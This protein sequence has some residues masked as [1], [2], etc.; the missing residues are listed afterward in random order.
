MILRSSPSSPFGRKCKM[1][2]MVLGLIDQIDIVPADTRDPQDSL[3][4]Q[5]PLGKI[6]ILITEDGLEL[7]DSPVICEYLDMKAGGGKLFP[8]GD[9]RWPALRLQALADGILDAAILQVYER[10]Y[11]TEDIVHQPWLDMQQGKVD[12]ALNW[13]EANTPEAGG[14]P[15]VGDITLAC[16]LSYLDFRF[17][18]DWREG[19]PRLVAWLE[20]FEK[21]V[22]AYGETKPHD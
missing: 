17:N 21:A 13:L 1:A 20:A 5:N 8:A 11:R 12:R 9:A 7:Y 4:K 2:A 15:N 10:R 3:R 14:E 18:G 22:P 6:P 19:R 16:A